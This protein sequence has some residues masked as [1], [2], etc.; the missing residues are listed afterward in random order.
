M[1]VTW[2][3][4]GEVLSRG[5][6]VLLFAMGMPGKKWVNNRHIKKMLNTAGH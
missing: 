6:C 5:T 3:S 2:Y 1:S 4:K